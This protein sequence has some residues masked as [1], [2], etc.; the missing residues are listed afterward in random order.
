MK[1]FLDN[2]I[3]DYYLG[4]KEKGYWPS[5]YRKLEYGGSLANG[6]KKTWIAVIGKDL[7]E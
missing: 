6:P 5:K 3:K 7:E 2:R 4:R 1:E